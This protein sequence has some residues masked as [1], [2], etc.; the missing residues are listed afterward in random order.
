MAWPVLVDKMVVLQSRKRLCV[1]RDLSP[2]DMVSRM[3]R[4]DNYL[5]GMLNKGVLAMRIPK[6]LPGAGPASGGEASAA[7]ESLLL[8]KTLEWTLQ[9]CIFDH[10][11]DE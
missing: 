1:A 8:T 5:I 10:M 4:K 9:W 11:F 6:W 7:S 2:H 3:M